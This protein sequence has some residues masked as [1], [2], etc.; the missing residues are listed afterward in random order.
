[1]QLRIEKRMVPHVPW[2]LIFCVLG[3]PVLGI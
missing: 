1:M 2:A 3:I